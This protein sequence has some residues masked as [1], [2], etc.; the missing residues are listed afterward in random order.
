M[1]YKCQGKNS[2]YVPSDED[3]LKLRSKDYRVT[4]CG[5]LICLQKRNFF[6]KLCFLLFRYNRFMKRYF[7]ENTAFD[8]LVFNYVKYDYNGFGKTLKEY[9]DC[10]VERGCSTFAQ[11]I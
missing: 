11:Y 4:F 7:N 1:E 10:L 8:A 2:F 9:G 5:S 3:V 6:D